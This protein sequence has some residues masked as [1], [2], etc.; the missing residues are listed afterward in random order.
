MF[1]SSLPP[2]VCRRAHVLFTLF[3]NSGDKH[4]LC[5][6]LISWSSSCVPY[7]ASFSGFSILDGPIGIL[8]RLFAS[9]SGLS[10]LD[11]TFGILYRLFRFINICL[12]F[13]LH[14]CKRYSTR[15]S[16]LQPQ[17]VLLQYNIF[18]YISGLVATL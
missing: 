13:L 18:V 16:V 4:I 10:I 17:Q 1:C 2:V 5:C 6:V 11:C 12:P 9:F 14:R 7:I 3:V 15:T 8:Q